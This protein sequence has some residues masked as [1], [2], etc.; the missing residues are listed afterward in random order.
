ML[1]NEQRDTGKKGEK[2]KKK[3][4]DEK[5]IYIDFFHRNKTNQ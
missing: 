5:P 4:S 3:E 1:R 2:K